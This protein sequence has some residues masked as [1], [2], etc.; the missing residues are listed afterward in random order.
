MQGLSFNS[1]KNLDFPGTW[2]K[3]S[4]FWDIWKQSHS[5]HLNFHSPHVASGE[6]VGHRWFNVINRMTTNLQRV[7]RL[8]RR[9]SRG[10]WPRSRAKW[11][12][13]TSLASS[14]TNRVKY[15]SK[16]FFQSFFK[17]VFF[18]TEMKKHK[19]IPLIFIYL[20]VWRLDM[21]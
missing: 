20:S 10:W 7:Q 21:F 4:K 19:K 9:R 8:R 17:Y 6:W 3:T 1:V 12:P 11:C 5:P 16:N 14:S 18:T 13:W 2:T 15:V